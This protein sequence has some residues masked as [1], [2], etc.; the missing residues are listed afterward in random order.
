MVFMELIANIIFNVLT[1]KKDIVIIMELVKNVL[2]DGQAQL[3]LLLFVYQICV[4]KVIK[5]F[6][7]GECQVKDNIRM[8]KCTDGAW[9]DFCEN[10]RES[11]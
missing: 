5:I 9:G 3:V 11:S 7:L 10:E 4:I 6:L 2:M 1:A 8:C